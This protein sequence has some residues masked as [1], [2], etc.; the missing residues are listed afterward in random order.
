MPIWC[1][2]RYY[3]HGWIKEATYEQR[4]FILDEMVYWDGNRV[5][6]RRQTEYSSKL[7]ENAI[8]MQTIAHTA[9]M[10]STVMK[11][12]NQFGEWY[13]ISILHAKRNKIWQ[14]MISKSSS[15]NGYVYCFTVPSGMILIRQEGHITVTGNCDSISSIEAGLPNCVS[16]PSGCE[17]FTWME[18]CWDFLQKFDKIILFGDSDAPGQEMVRKLIQKLGPYRCWTVDNKYKDANELLFREGPEAVR[19]AVENARP[20]PIVGLMELADVEP[21]DT[22]QIVRISTGIPAL[23]SSVGGLQRGKLSLWTGKRASGKS[24]LAGQVLLEAIDNGNTVCAYSGELSGEDFQYWIHLQAAGKSHINGYHDDFRKKN[25]Y[26]VD[27]KTTAKIMD[28][29]RGKFYIYDNSVI[30]GN[31][32]E[33]TS[34][35]KIFEYASQRYDCK[36]YLVDNLMTARTEYG[37]NND[38]Y[39][40]QANFVIQLKAFAR[41]YNV[42]VMLVVHPKKNNNNT[43]FDNDD[44][45]GMTVIPDIADDVYRISRKD[46]EDYDILLKVGKNRSDGA[47]DNIGLK[48]CKVSRRIYQASV[49]DIKEYG[50]T[51][52]PWE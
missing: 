38:F 8:F 10:M 7:I 19:L 39:Q 16:V 27:K 46:H 23:D 3:P 25:V 48:F 47:N 30:Y 4:L 42:H 24:T 37:N 13:K 34:I 52:T 32:D 22:R 49:G 50:W 6:D 44:I 20:V 12:K 29:Y 9:D 43:D 31:K 2:G 33:S 17:D 35:L 5:P 11:R 51:K 36:V 45:G 40:D 15:Y 14:K 18:T 41:N 1:P 21:L 28:W 26:F